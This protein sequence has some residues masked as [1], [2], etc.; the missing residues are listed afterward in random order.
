MTIWYRPSHLYY[1]GTEHAGISATRQ[2]LLAP[3][4]KRHEVFSESHE[5]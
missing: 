3:S 2:T 4:A 1:A 5:G